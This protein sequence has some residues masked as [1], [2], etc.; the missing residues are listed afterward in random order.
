MN[1]V[2]DVCRSEQWFTGQVQLRLAS[3]NLAISLSEQG[4]HAEA[5]EIE[6][7]VLVQKIRLFGIDHEETLTCATN[8]A[9]SL[10]L[11]GQKVEGG[12]LLHGT[13]ALFR[14]TPG[15]THELT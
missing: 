1:L 7:E 13:M 12:Q 15:P 11:G 2:C 10:S 5:V 9:I 3:S 8:L 6:R 4:R 14:R